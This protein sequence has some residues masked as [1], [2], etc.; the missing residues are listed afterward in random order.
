MYWFFKF[1]LFVPFVRLFVRPHVIGVENVPKHGPA[2][3]APN[4][5]AIWDAILVPTMTPRQVTFPAKAELFAPSKN[6]L[7]MIV[8]WFLKAVGQVPVDRSGGRASVNSLEA[9]FE[10]L[11][12]GRVVGI[13]PEGTR[14]PDGRLHR[15]KTGVARLALQGRV[16][17]I[18][19]GLRHTFPRGRLRLPHRP[20]IEFGTPLTYAQY[21]GQGED[22]H[23]VRWV[24]DDI[25][26]AVQKMTGQSYVEVYG[27]T[28][29]KNPDMDLGRL[30]FDNPHHGQAAPAVE[31]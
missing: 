7:K 25:L 12:E 15:G 23:V 5:I 19:V 13:F 30:S 3:L 22:R 17:V 9:I 4:H 11:R 6:P 18:P 21:Y 29:K 20:I 27:A 31:A 26:A 28:H 24:T 1:T 14:S 2:I 16:P 10:A 8:A